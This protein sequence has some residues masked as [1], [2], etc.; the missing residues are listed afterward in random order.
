MLPLGGANW[1]G[2]PSEP[3]SVSFVG[4]NDNSPE[5]AIAV[6]ISGDARKFIVLVFPSLRLL[7]FLQNNDEKKVTSE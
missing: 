4:L 3:I 5:N 2:V 1:N 7:K 6:T